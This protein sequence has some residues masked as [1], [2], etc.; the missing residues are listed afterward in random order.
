MWRENG[1]SPKKRADGV[2]EIG[3]ERKS[4]TKLYQRIY[5]L[6]KRYIQK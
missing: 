1:Y 3:T 4:S 2:S 5:L 6:K